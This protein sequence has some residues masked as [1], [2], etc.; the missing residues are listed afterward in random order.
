MDIYTDGHLDGLNGIGGVFANSGYSLLK[1][2]DKTLTINYLKQSLTNNEA[3]MLSIFHAIVLAKKNDTI[4]SDSQI[5]I[6]LS[7]SGK[8]NEPRLQLISIANKYLIDK[9]KIKLQ[10]ISRENNP[11]T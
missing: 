3:E 11:V 8:S 9:K 5:A 10:W 1:I 7:K 6:N 4:F 2:K